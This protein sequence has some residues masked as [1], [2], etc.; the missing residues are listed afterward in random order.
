M[1]LLPIAPTIAAALLAALAASGCTPQETA[2]AKNMA[3]WV[4]KVATQVEKTASQASRQECP[5]GQDCPKRASGDAIIPMRDIQEA[6][7]MV[8]NA[9][10]LL[11]S[12][13]SEVEKMPPPLPQR[14]PQVV[15]APGAVGSVTQT[16]PAPQVVPA[17]AAGGAPIVE[18]P[19]AAP[20]I[21]SAPVFVAP[22]AAPLQAPVGGDVHAALRA[23]AQ[24]G[25][26][27]AAQRALAAGAAIDRG[28]ERNGNTPLILAANHG[29]TELVRLLVR[30]GANLNRSNDSGVNALIAAVMSGNQ[31]AAGLL[32]EQGANLNATD[33]NGRTALSL[34]EQSGQGA[35]ATMLRAAGA[36]G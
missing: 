8:K 16:T 33:K 20:S 21:A 6:A 25:D 31:A 12:I 5:E 1:K 23:A 14:A 24:S 28:D 29:H 18:A 17:P 7:V 2:D 30:S 35:L 19:K 4:S 36:K 3:E 11:A 13:A 22:G 9:A 15:P 10:A 27:N 32:I 26:V 34:A